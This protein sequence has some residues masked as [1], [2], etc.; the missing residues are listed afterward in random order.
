MDS[1]PEYNLDAMSRARSLALL[2]GAINGDY[3]QPS[4]EALEEICTRLSDGGAWL[5]VFP[6]VASIGISASLEGPTHSLRLTKHEGAAVQF[7]DGRRGERR[8]FVERRV[9][10]LDVYSLGPKLLAEKVGLTPPKCRAVIDHR[11]LERN[12]D[13]F[14]LIK[15]GR[16][17]YSRYS[18]KAIKV[19]EETLETESIDE[20]WAGYRE[21]Q[22]EKQRQKQRQRRGKDAWQVT[23]RTK[24]TIDSTIARSY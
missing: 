8:M 5:S 24:P 10:E 6:G 23:R 7:D 12:P 11:Q 13:L 16:T 15:V 4:D 1:G 9:N 21:K 20:I 22:R 3:E 17:S 14:K 2:E 18:P 19:I